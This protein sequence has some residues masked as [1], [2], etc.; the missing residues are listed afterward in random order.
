VTESS[1]PIEL[2]VALYHETAPARFLDGYL[3]GFPEHAVEFFIK[4]K[5]VDRVLQPGDAGTVR[6]PVFASPA[7][8]VPENWAKEEWFVYRIPPGP[9]TAADEDLREAAAAILAAYRKSRA[10]YIG[11]GKPGIARDGYLLDS[12]SPN[13]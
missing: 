2:F 1:D 8:H 11:D 3:F 13:M 5:R 12:G 4:A 7:V 6:I 9:E 10:L